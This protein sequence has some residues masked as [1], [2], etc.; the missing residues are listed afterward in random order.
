M[1]RTDILIQTDTAEGVWLD[2]VSA[3]CQRDEA[4]AADI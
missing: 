1:L 2:E 4:T 3:V